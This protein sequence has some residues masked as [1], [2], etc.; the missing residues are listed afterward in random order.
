MKRRNLTFNVA[1][2]DKI[3]PKKSFATTLNFKNVL[4]LQAMLLPNGLIPPRRMTRFSRTTQNK[5]A[6]EIKKCR[7]LGLIPNHT[8]ITI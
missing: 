5:F 6:S 4:S 8:A 7:Y 1:R 3:L 2:E